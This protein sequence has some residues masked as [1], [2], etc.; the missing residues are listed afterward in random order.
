[1]VSSGPR[2]VTVP[3]VVGKAQGDAQEALAVVPLTVGQ[4]TPQASETVP[5]GSVISTAPEAGK[6]V[7]SGSAVDLVVSTGPPPATV[8]DVIGLTEDDAANKLSDAGL[9]KGDVTTDETSSEKA[10]T[11]ISSDPAAGQERPKGSKVDLVLAPPAVAPTL[12]TPTVETPTLET[13][14]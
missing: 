1:V 10:G 5:E 8:P 6:E 2:P 11:V 13:P 12:E 14:G 7:D 3:D 4:V 9:V